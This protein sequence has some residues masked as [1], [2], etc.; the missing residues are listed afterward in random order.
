MGEG[1]TEA[2][3]FASVREEAA[4]G[5][6][7]ALPTQATS[8]A[9]HAR[10]TDFLERHRARHVELAL[11]H[12]SAR[13]EALVERLEAAD[14]EGLESAVTAASWF[15]TGRRELLAEV[16][17]GTVDQSLFA[18][19]P[20][21]HHFVRLWALQG[22]VVVL[23]EVHAYDAY[24]GGLLQ[25]LVRWLAALHCT[26]VMMS[27]TLPVNV[28]EELLVAFGEGQG[29]EKV[30]LAPIGYPRVTVVDDDGV[31][32]E[33]A[34]ASRHQ[35]LEIRAAPFDVERLGQAVLEAVRVGG[36]VA[37]VLNRVARAQALFDWCRG[38]DAV[39]VGVLV[40]VHG[41]L[42]L[43]ARRQ[44]EGEVMRRFGRD[45]TSDTRRG[46]V[47][48]TQVL[49]QSLDL[50]FDVMFTDLAPIDLLLQRAGRMH[51]HEGRQRPKGHADAVLHVAGLRSR[52]DGGPAQETLEF[53]Y[54]AYVVWRT[55]AVLSDRAF[56]ELPEDIDRTV[57]L[58]YGDEP[59]DA[60]GPF[61]AETKQAGIVHRQRVRKMREAARLWSVAQ[62]QQPATEGWREG[63]TDDD[64][65]AD[66]VA[67]AR[68]RLGGESLNVIPVHRSASGWRVW[69]WD[70]AAVPFDA[71]RAA[72]EWAK[73]AVARQIRIA[74]PSLIHRL[75][76][77]HV[78]SWWNAHPLLVRFV[79]L[80]FDAEDRAVLEPGVRLDRDLGLIYPE[81]RQS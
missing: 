52:P 57:Q 10:L 68:T 3:F 47:I 12:A 75:A 33:A 48:A 59:L 70:G 36:A 62:P 2:S 13:V 6:Y 49:E 73:A 40:L 69:G 81:G 66:Y 5:A 80:E 76:R 61:Q 20:V 21:R 30:N 46:L 71:R 7:F 27:A 4:V 1:K 25:E 56:L 77:R 43:D 37:C 50:D 42:P 53:P 65:P 74:R 78:P 31:R 18:V 41:R 60:L 55:W 16:G 28:R 9:M 51:R 22:K 54:S 19:L 72:A 44:R 15:S 64:T 35:R 67:R 79:P 45:S 29:R 26:V 38:R 14:A 11:A 34:S 17:V 23:D 58:V 32:S 63:A 24:T 8:D 39:D